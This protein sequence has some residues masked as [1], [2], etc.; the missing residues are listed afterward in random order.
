MKIGRVG[1]YFVRLGRLGKPGL[2]AAR[3]RHDFVARH[4]SIDVLQYRACVIVA[5]KEPLA[6]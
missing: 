1:I 4:W 6:T 3:Y 2:F 5:K